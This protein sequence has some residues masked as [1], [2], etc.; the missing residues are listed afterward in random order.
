MELHPVDPTVL[1]WSSS[2]FLTPTTCSKKVLNEQKHEKWRRPPWFC[3]A[4]E[5]NAEK[6]SKGLQKASNEELSRIL[7]TE[8]AIKAIERK[9]SSKN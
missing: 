1:R 3:R 2:S 6:V 5:K 4:A 7:R 9:A 8:A